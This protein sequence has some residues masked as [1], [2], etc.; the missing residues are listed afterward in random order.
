[1]RQSFIT[2]FSSIDADWKRSISILFG[3]IGA[4]WIICM[5]ILAYKLAGGHF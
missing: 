5:I 1:M 3:G 2:L 4:G